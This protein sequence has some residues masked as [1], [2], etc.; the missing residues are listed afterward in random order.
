MTLGSETSRVSGAAV[1]PGLFGLLRVSPARGRFIEPA[2]A[3]PGAA[4]VVVITA[5][6]WHDRFGGDPEVVGRTMLLDGR[7]HTVVG[8]TPDGFA[9][10]DREAL[11]YTP[12]VPPSDAQSFSVFPVVARLKPGATATQ[13]AA[14][15]TTA[16][17]SVT[18][19][20]VADMLFASGDRDFRG[21]LP[22]GWPADAFRALARCRP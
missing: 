10:P 2:E 12:Y 15:G 11:L 20:M 21:R 17:R 6:L 4:G 3:V 22:T 8:I 19:G 9:F 1:S 13:A 18:R 16:A 5:T 14:E 7:L